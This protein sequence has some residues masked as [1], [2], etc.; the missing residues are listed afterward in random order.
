[1]PMTSGPSLADIRAAAA[2]W[3]VRLAD[4]GASEADLID[5]DRWLDLSAE[6]QN[7]YDEALATWLQLEERD[8][9]QAAAA[10]ARG[11]PARRRVRRPAVWTAAGALAAAALAAS[12]VLVVQPFGP[13]PARPIIYSTGRG[14]MRS[15]TLADGTRLQLNALTR[16]SVQ[17]GPKARRVTLAEGEAAL[18]VVHD[19]ARPFVVATTGG[20]IR[21]VGTEFDVRQRGGALSVT[22]AHGVVDFE[23]ADKGVA[24]PVRLAAGE[25]LEWAADG[26][27]IRVRPVSAEDDLSWRAGRLV[28]RNQTLAV[29]VEELNLHFDRPIRIASPELAQRRITGVLQIDTEA[30]TL[31]RLTLFAPITATSHGRE[32][33][34]LPAGRPAPGS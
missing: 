18:D 21:D 28:L 26:K 2:G 1:M 27:S 12:V 8:T 14:E 5:F 13:A 30:A 17:L 7:A 22:V 24:A 15:V 3:V 11:L 32:I 9:P 6:H 33:L 23:P 10:Q 25:R 31:H 34:L 16:V 19:P 4:P 20:E 29:V